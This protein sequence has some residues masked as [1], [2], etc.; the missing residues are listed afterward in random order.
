MT[1][2]LPNKL[3]YIMQF[4]T[5]A[6]PDE[7]QILEKRVKKLEKQLML[8]NKKLEKL[9]KIKNGNK[10]ERVEYNKILLDFV[11]CFSII[12]CLLPKG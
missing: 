3:N 6:L 10:S 4:L 12:D 5:S 7:K 1:I 9:Q 11:Y 8:A 2:P